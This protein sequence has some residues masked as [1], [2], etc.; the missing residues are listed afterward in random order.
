[1]KPVRFRCRKYLFGVRQASLPVGSGGILPRMCTACC[2]RPAGR[3]MV[4]KRIGE[5]LL[6]SCAI[7]SLSAGKMPA[8]R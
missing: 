1:M 7:A 6:R 2:Q 5:W 3:G 8:A 4:V